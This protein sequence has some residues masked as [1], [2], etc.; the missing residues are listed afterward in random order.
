MGSSGSMDNQTVA[1]DDLVRSPHI[2]LVE[3]RRE[4]EDMGGSEVEGFEINVRGGDWT[5][6]LFRV[7]LPAPWA[8]L[9]DHWSTSHCLVWGLRT[10][11]SRRP[12]VAPERS[13]V[14]DCF[15]LRHRVG[16]HEGRCR[17]SRQDRATFDGHSWRP[18]LKAPSAAICGLNT[19]AGPQAQ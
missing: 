12:P 10:A 11:R 3:K 14:R 5:G 2:T 18:F 15:F 9:G 1:G 8:E 16:R 4:W 19:G 7:K 17:D 13:L 6:R